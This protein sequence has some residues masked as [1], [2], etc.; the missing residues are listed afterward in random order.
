MLRNEILAVEATPETLATVLVNND[1]LV[2]DLNFMTSMHNEAKKEEEEEDHVELP[3]DLV[4]IWKD[5]IERIDDKVGAKVLLDALVERICKED[6]EEEEGQDRR[7]DCAAWVVEL[8]EALL[9]RSDLLKLKRW[10]CEAEDLETW[11]C[12]PNALVQML[13]PCFF[14]LV[15]LDRGRRELLEMV[16]AATLGDNEALP[17]GKQGEEGTVYSVE[18]LCSE[19]LDAEEDKSIEIEKNTH[20]KTTKGW[21][22]EKR[23]AGEQLVKTFPPQSWSSLWLPESAEWAKPSSPNSAATEEVSTPEFELERVVWPGEEALGQNGHL[24]PA[25]YRSNQH[26]F[27]SPR[28]KRTKRI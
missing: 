7:E 20:Q 24:F 9:G 25:F 15:S 5:F 13:L 17:M 12:R 21:E 14:E 27:A 10:P 22:K 3:R 23:W 16:V 8:S 2:P 11:L 19:K 4:H 1:L 6:D 26:T 28:R 18:D